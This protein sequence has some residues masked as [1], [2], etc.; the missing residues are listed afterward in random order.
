MSNI[1]SRTY[2]NY[3]KPALQDIGDVL[4]LGTLP[5][6]EK[7]VSAAESGLKGL[8]SDMS[9]RNAAQEGGRAE[10]EINSQVQ[11]IQSQMS[12]YI[13]AGQYGINALTTAMQPGGSLTG[14]APAAYNIQ[15]FSFD[16]SNPAYQA[17]QQAAMDAA[18]AG[19]AGMGNFGSGNMLSGLQ[20]NASNL[21][22]QE[23]QNQYQNWLAGQGLGLQGQNQNY[24][25]FMGQ[26]QNLYN[27]LM[28]MGQLGINSVLN[29]GQLALGGTQAGLG[30][31]ASGYDAQQQAINSLY[32]SVGSGMQMGGNAFNGI[33]NYFGGGGTAASTGVPTEAQLGMTLLK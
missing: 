12:P 17:N 6:I 18:R 21:A 4:T 27:E 2:D 14:K 20:K 24:N 8:W 9:G 32:G 16:S 11:N 3:V 25:Q 15:P 13:N 19:S 29:T 26:N 1:I 5:I 7:G 23:Y 10:A 28:G 30:A 33:Q 31:R 22:S